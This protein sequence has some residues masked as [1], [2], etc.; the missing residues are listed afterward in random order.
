MRASKSC[1]LTSNF[2]SAVSCL[3]RSKDLISHEI[4]RGEACENRLHK[5][6]FSQIKHPSYIPLQFWCRVR[7][8]FEPS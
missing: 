8:S 3:P 5:L 1:S 7:V 4:S 2:A 6:S